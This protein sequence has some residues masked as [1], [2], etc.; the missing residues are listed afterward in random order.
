MRTAL[1]LSLLIFSAGCGAPEQAQPQVK[2]EDRIPAP[3]LTASELGLLHNAKVLRIGDSPDLVTVAFPRPAVAYTFKDLP[4]G[5][6]SP[7]RAEGYETTRDGF[8]A[9]YYQ[10]QLAFAMHREQDV[11]LEDVAETRKRYEERFGNATTQLTGGRVY[12]LFWE[13]D[14]HRLMIC[15]AK[16]HADPSRYDLTIAVGDKTVMDALRMNYDDAVRDKDQAEKQYS[17]AVIPN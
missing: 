3:K 13:S 1:W 15:S 6:A 11:T 5:F 2:A 9:I 8:G 7:Y 12:Y 10:G 17:E 4:P 16:D 14:E